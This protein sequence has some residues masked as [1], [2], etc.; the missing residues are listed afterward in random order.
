MFVA[1]ASKK[2][3]IENTVQEFAKKTN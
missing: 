3:L 1:N 2:F